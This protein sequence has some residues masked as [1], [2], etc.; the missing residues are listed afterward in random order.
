MQLRERLA[1]V[2]KRRVTLE[3]AVSSARA[4]RKDTVSSY[5]SARVYDMKFSLCYIMIILPSLVCTNNMCIDHCD[6][7][8]TR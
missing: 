1:D 6:T 5:H 2:K 8:N 7:V 3:E 4:L